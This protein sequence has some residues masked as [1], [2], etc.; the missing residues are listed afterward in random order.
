MTDTEQIQRPVTLLTGFLG[1]G[2]TTLLN[3]YLA[4]RQHVRFAIIENEIGEESIDGELLV[5]TED[6]FVEM[7]N[8]CICC[9][10]NDNFLEILKGLYKRREQWYEL[11]IEATGIA[12]PAG[13]ALPFL[14][15]AA[16][17]RDF[18]LERI[19]CLVDVERIEDQL[20]ETGEAVRQIAF[21]DILLFN[22]TDQV[23]PEYLGH[24]QRLMSGINPM[25]LI[26]AENRGTYPLHEMA[27]YV[28][29]PTG[30]DFPL[31][32]H[33]HDDDDAHDGTHKHG[34]DDHR[35]DD[36]GQA[37]GHAHHSH[38][39]IKAISF[40]FAEPF[41]TDMLARRLRAFLLFQAKDVY[42][43]K[44]IFYDSAKFSKVI[45]QSV[46]KSLLVTSGRSWKPQE[47]KSS[48]I[49]FIGK[50]LRPAGFEKMLRH[51]IRRPQKQL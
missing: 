1:A 42:R 39:D 33:S 15:N 26:M 16:V 14:A 34:H 8:G 17:A 27:T 4:F 3:E 32:D 6:S 20:Q 23:C 13:V 45:F 38:S 46:G 19:I 40:S 10:L 21:G 51:C 2:K 41:D 12:D 48:K 29:Q 31:G 5:Q 22:K 30:D 11:I 44:G 50:Q 47:S 9:T 49:V 35:D 43:I 28:R 37:T 25:A 7:N 18:R 36:H 24:L